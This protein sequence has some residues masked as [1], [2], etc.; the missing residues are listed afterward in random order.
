MPTFSTISKPMILRSD[1][2]PATTQ[3]APTYYFVPSYYG[4]SSWNTNRQPS[5]NTTDGYVSSGYYYEPPVAFEI[6]SDITDTS[7]V[8]LMHFNALP[9]TDETGRLWSDNSVAIDSES[10]PP[11]SN[12]IASLTSGFL[13]AGASSDFNFGAGDFTIEFWTFGAL[14]YYYFQGEWNVDGSTVGAIDF[15]KNF[16]VWETDAHEV[17]LFEL[18]G[19]ALTGWTHLAV[20]R[21]G[22]L[23]RLFHNGLMVD[24]GV[25]ESTIDMSRR[26]IIEE[27]VY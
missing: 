3:M 25:Y 6:D 13:I 1:P 5:I 21:E 16:T 10:F 19:P 20:T 27:K 11:L 24:S 22:N 23:F 12:N 14:N 4:S 17:K 9:I 26:V 2:N 15:D 8:T 7:I 18:E